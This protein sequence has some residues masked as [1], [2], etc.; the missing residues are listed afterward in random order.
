M[1]LVELFKSQNKTIIEATIT[2]LDHTEDCIECSGHA[3]NGEKVLMV[4][5]QSKYF[6]NIVSFLCPVCFEKYP[7]TLKELNDL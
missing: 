2:I 6:N 1:N 7:M 4:K 3:H 5:W